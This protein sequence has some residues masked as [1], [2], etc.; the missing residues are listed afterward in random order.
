MG[1]RIK[2][3]EFELE[4]GE[5]IELEIWWDYYYK[6]AKIYGK[7]EDCYPAESES[8]LVLE[9]GWQEKVKAA[10]PE[11]FG[12]NIKNI[13]CQNDCLEEEVEQWAKDEPPDIDE[14]TAYEFERDRERGRA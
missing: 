12:Q 2:N 1:S 3:Y 6:P 14:D 11:N 5:F 10:D 13:E 7:P 9:K 8:T 4:N